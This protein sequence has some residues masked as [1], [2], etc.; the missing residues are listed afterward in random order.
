M[1][2]PERIDVHKAAAVCGVPPRTVQGLAAQGRVPGAAKIGRRWTFS[3]AKLRQWIEVLEAATRRRST[4]TRGSG[5]RFPPPSYDTAYEQAIERLKRV[6][7]AS[8]GKRQRHR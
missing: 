6:G 7:S 8:G 4:P 1:T 2:N 5:S 3:E